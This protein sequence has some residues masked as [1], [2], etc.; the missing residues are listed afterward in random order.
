MTPYRCV[1]AC[2]QN[3]K[4]RSFT[5]QAAIKMSVGTNSVD[6]VCHRVKFSVITSILKME[7]KSVFETLLHVKQP[8]RR[9]GTK[10][11]IWIMW[12]ICDLILET[13]L[14]IIKTI[15]VLEFY[16]MYLTHLVRLLRSCSSGSDVVYLCKLVPNVIATC[17]LDITERWMNFCPENWDNIFLQ[18][19]HISTNPPYVTFLKTSL[20]ILL[21]WQSHMPHA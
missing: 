6:Q 19:I 3:T 11:I 4:P 16:R 13:V 14:H 17:C 9:H 10:F 15:I 7:A 21:R 8:T 2:Y 18:N 1:L 20:F 5:V 12:R